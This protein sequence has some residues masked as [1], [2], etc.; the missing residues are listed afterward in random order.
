MGENLKVD[1]NTLTCV[2]GKSFKRAKH[3][4]EFCIA[5]SQ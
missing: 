1:C 2:F 4:T 5:E 3:T